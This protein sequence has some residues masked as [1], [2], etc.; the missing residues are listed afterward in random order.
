[1]IGNSNHFRII[2]NGILM[3]ALVLLLSGCFVF[4]K[5]CNC[6]TWSNNDYLQTDKLVSIEQVKD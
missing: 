1:M 2:H 4:R 6:P 5:N 3:L